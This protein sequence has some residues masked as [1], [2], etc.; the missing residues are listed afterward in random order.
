M[1]RFDYDDEG[2][3]PYALWRQ[4]VRNALQGKRGQ[5]ALREIEAA[6]LA[7]PEPRLIE[8]SLCAETPGRPYEFCVVGAW[9][10]ARILAGNGPRG[11]KTLDDLKDFDDEDPDQ[12]ADLGRVMGCAYAM[13]WELGQQNDYHGA[14]PESRYR[15]VL[16]WVRGQIKQSEPVGG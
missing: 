9:A 15:Y 14:S 6:L 7:L 13:A 2:D 8:G 3:I 16:S 12:T 5:K 4:T 11:L 10:R 1:S